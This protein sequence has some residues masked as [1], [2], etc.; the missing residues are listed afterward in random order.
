MDNKLQNILSLVDEYIT[1]KH[2]KKTWEAG[3][4]WVQY[5]G[6]YFTSD[7]Y[8]RS[9]ESLLKEWLVL[10]NDA[11][12]FERKFPEF[13]GKRNGVL[14]NSGSSSNLLMMVAMTSKNLH[15]F[16]KGTKVIT[17]IAGFPTTLNPIYQVGFEPVFVDIQLDN[18]NLDLSKVE[19]AVRRSGAK[20]ITFAHVLGNPPNMD[21]LS[22]ICKEYNIELIM[23]GCDSLGS[24]YKRRNIV[25]YAIAWSNSFY[26]SH[27]ITTGEGGM[28]CSND[29]RIIST[30]RSMAWWGRDCYCVGAGNLL[31]N[32]TC[33]NRFDKWLP[34][35]EGIMDHKYIFTN[36]GYNLKPLDLQGA[37]GLAQLEKV[38]EIHE[39]RRAAKF[40]LEEMFEKYCGVFVPKED[41]QA[42]TS[43]FGTP[44][45]CSGK[46]EKDLLV[47]YLEMNKIQT[48]NYFAGNI[49]LHPGYS[50]L[51]DWMDYP[52]SNKVLDKVFFIGSAPHYTDEVFDYIELKLQ[53]RYYN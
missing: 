37:I 11:Q 28:V 26:P 24:Q 5:A 36:L 3:K 40:R 41:E 6:P 34:N 7:E 30:A 49:L 51:G 25:D 16:P 27:H 12:K 52:E 53:E 17:P 29:E 32:G 47:S 43:W 1:E 44:I 31:A 48:R 21:I 46:K 23:D 14:T 45:V 42:E 35:Y 13:F 20:I 19:E 9:I 2:S 38:D 22:D 15:N 10:G 39:K 33:G 50:N 8:V 4:D 18:L